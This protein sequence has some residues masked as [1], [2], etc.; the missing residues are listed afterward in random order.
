[1]RNIRAHFVFKERSKMS[2]TKKK[3]QE[4]P[5][6]KRNERGQFVK[7]NEIG[8]ET[9]VKKGET[10]SLKYK[11]EYCTKLLEYF[12]KPSTRVEY[13]KTYVKGEL[14]SETPILLPEEYPTFEL[15]AASIG[16]SV[17]AL[18][19]WRDKYPQF[20]DAY[21]RAKEIQLG[22]LTSCAVMGL[23]NPLYAKFEA[24]NN[25]NQKDKSEVETN[26]SAVDEKTLALIQRVEA[27]LS[28]GGQED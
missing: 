1:M 26:V 12:S 9:R 18:A 7:G 3:S 15:F 16:V 19:D 8:K 6:K 21:A 5:T 10:L 4:E 17:R 2:Q 11:E 24:V 23:Y 14:S 13:K 28:N 27:R 25:H 20:A 22:K